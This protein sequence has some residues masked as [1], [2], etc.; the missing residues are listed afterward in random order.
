MDGG[1]ALRF[2]TEGLKLAGAPVG[3]HGPLTLGSW[4]PDWRLDFAGLK[5]PVAARLLRGWVGEEVLPVGLNGAVTGTVSLSGPFTDLRV[6]GAVENR[7]LSYGPISFD[8]LAGSFRVEDGVLLVDR[9]T[10]SAGTGQLEADGELAFADGTLRLD[11]AA[12]RWPLERLARWAEVEQSVAGTVD[13][14]GTL[15]GRLDSP[16]LSSRL[17]LSDVAFAGV[18]FGGG[19]AQLQIGDGIVRLDGLRVGPLAADVVVDV[20]RERATIDGSLAG[21][22][23]GGVAPV[24][25]RLAGGPVDLTVSADF[26]FAQPAG[27]LT[28]AGINGLSGFAELDGDRLRV[29]VERVDRWRLGGDAT[30]AAGGLV[31]RVEVS[32]AAL[33]ETLADLAGS[34]V[35][36]SGRVSGSADVSIAPDGEVRLAGQVAEADL[37]VGGQRAALARPAAFSFEHGDVRVPGLQLAGEGSSLFVRGGRLADGTLFGNFAGEMSLAPLGLFWPDSDPRGRV[38]AIG[39]LSGTDAAPRIEGTARVTGASLRVPGSMLRL[40]ASP[41]SSAVGCRDPGSTACASPG[42]GAGVCSGGCCS[43]ASRSST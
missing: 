20:G 6:E 4:I 13:A 17:M 18:S 34:P 2:A 12:E 8:V 14:V 1:N 26:P 31:G 29:A 30:R 35:G 37:E 40:P 21:F 32:I 19:T 9:A 25:A 43:P 22:R 3:W 27:R 42:S 28:V 11:L 36:L 38:E 5:V 16:R 7:P 39:E 10:G 41:V 15:T 23:L 24:L 33:R